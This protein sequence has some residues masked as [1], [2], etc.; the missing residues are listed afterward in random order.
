SHP[1]PLSTLPYTALFPSRS[2]PQRPSSRRGLQGNGQSAG[3]TGCHG[4]DCARDGFRRARPGRRSDRVIPLH[5]GIFRTVPVG[6]YRVTRGK[7]FS[8]YSSWIL[9]VEL[10]STI[11]PGR[12]VAGGTCPPSRTRESRILARVSSP[13]PSAFTP[14]RLYPASNAIQALRYAITAGCG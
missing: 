9:R 1:L 5:E 8:K 10:A 2:F 7:A 11:F 13:V 12:L 6:P 14:R 4:R 3:W